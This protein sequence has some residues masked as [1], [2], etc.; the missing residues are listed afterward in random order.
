MQADRRMRTDA[1]Q[2]RA[3]MYADKHADTACYRTDSFTGAHTQ[4]SVK[5]ILKL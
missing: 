1:V 2:A 5:L 3:R 4:H